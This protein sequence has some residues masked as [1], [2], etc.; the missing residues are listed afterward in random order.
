M[1]SVVIH[2]IDAQIDLVHEVLSNF[3]PQSV[4]QQ[5]LYPN[6]DNP[7]L[8]IEIVQDLSTF[9]YEKNDLDGIEKVL[10][11]KPDISILADVSGRV[12]GNTEVRAFVEC[13]L[14][15]FRG[16][17][18]DDYT[19]HPWTLE[20][21]RSNSQFHGHRFFDYDGHHYHDTVDPNS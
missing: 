20:E 19:S 15:R 12:P 9:A 18:H 5:W 13:L 8:Y 4:P 14:T 16:I 1:R 10:G 3:S 7:S 11:R 21:I 6:V 2:L 17:A